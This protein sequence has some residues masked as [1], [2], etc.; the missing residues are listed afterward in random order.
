MNNITFSLIKIDISFK[1]LN[2]NFY[3]L[4]LKD[5]F[6][7]KMGGFK[8]H[9]YELDGIFL[10]VTIWPTF[11]SLEKKKSHFLSITKDDKCLF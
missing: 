3:L 8:F 5:N 1:L 11:L 6:Y 2:I 9:M 10:C 4:L 7:R